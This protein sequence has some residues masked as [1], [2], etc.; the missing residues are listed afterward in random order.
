MHLED[1]EKI[2]EMPSDIVDTKW[3]RTDA[4]IEIMMSFDKYISPIKNY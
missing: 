4:P 3:K 2:I 1:N